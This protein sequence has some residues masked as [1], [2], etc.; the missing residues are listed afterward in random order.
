MIESLKKLAVGCFGAILCSCSPAFGVKNDTKSM[1]YI[2]TLYV[3][4][5]R[6]I[7][8]QALEPGNIYSAPKCWRDISGLYIGF[9]ADDLHKKN[10]GRICRKDSCNCL[11]K[12]S[13]L[14][15]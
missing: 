6:P 10:I 1:V 15:I 12:V 4:S 5:P 11:V 3:N 2:D 13:K 9:Q 8:P 14:S 7:A